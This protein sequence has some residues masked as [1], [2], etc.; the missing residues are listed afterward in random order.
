MIALVKGLIGSRV[1]RKWSTDILDTIF[2]FNVLFLAVFTSYSLDKL[3]S[4][5]E[6]AAFISVE[7]SLVS[8]LLI[9]IYHMYTYT[10]IFSK[11]KGTKAGRMV[12]RL[13]TES[14]TKQKT[15]H[16]QLDAPH[17]NDIHRF[18]ELLDI[19]DRPVNTDDY[20]VPQGQNLVGPTHSVVEVHKPYLAPEAVH[21]ESEEENQNN[22][23][24]Q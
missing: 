21:L 14:E 9:V 10:I 8:L 16:C 19:I 13:L 17:D 11:F 3:D 23:G 7:I 18:N 24:E 6:A 5:R 2:Y 4:N 22:T 12:D 1:Y 20:N 15:N